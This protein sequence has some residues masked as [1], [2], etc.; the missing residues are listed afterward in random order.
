MPHVSDQIINDKPLL[1]TERL[2]FVIIATISPNHEHI[3]GGTNTDLVYIWNKFL[4]TNFR[5]D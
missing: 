2:V 3:K 1:D 4:F 5:K